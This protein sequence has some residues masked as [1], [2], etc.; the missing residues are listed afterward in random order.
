MFKKT[1]ISFYKHILRS[2]QRIACG[3]FFKYMKHETRKSKKSRSVIS[4]NPL[5]SFILFINKAP[6]ELW[7]FECRRFLLSNLFI[8]KHAS[9]P[10]ICKGY[11]NPTII[12]IYEAFNQL[13]FY[14]NAA[15]LMVGM[16]KQTFS[17]L[18]ISHKSIR[19]F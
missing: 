12:S 5:P 1:D 13:L 8:L 7:K 16:G 17:K 11:E 6:V 10:N 14:F 2:S 18:K 9:F 3:F 15:N 19:F 4:E